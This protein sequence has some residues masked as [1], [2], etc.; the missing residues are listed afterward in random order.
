MIDPKLKNKVAIVTGANHGIGATTAKALSAQGV[1]VFITYYRIPPEDKSLEIKSDPSIPGDAMYKAN[2][3]KDATEVLDAIKQ[4]G[5]QAVAYEYDLSNTDVIKEMF[6]K[7]EQEL[8]SVE[9]LVNNAAY[10]KPDT[11]LFDNDEK[12]V[13]GHSMNTISAETHDKHFAINSRAVALMMNEFTKRYQKSNGSG[14]RIINISSDGDDCFPTEVS[15]GAS[16]AAL[17]SY[18]RSAAVEFGPLGITVNVLSLGAVQTGWMS[19]EIEKQELETIPLRKIGQPEDVADVIVF[20]ASDQAR[21]ITGQ[22]IYVGG[23]HRMI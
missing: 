18:S 3:A 22:K 19:P 15:Y 14:G 1:K 11:L 9:I 5:G 21:W 23:G 17:V 7:A 2:L 16:K 4:I 13:S 12:S 20:L 10:C 6:D 8:G